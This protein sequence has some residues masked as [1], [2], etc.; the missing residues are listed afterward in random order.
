MHKFQ[1]FTNLI[2]ISCPFS[3][4]PSDAQ[5]KDGLK[6]YFRSSG[7]FVPGCAGIPTAALDYC[8]DPVLAKGSV[9]ATNNIQDQDGLGVD[10]ITTLI[11]PKPT[12]VMIQPTPT[13]SPTVAPEAKP[14]AKPTAKPMAKPTAKPTPNPT[15]APQPE[16]DR[17]R[18]TPC[19]P[20]RDS[21]WD[22]ICEARERLLECKKKVREEQREGRAAGA[23]DIALRPDGR[24]LRLYCRYSYLWQE[25]KQYCPRY[26]LEASDKKVGATLEIKDCSRSSPLQKFR[27][28]DGVIR[29]GWHG[30]ERLCI[31]SDKL[32]RCDKPL[33]YEREGN[34]AHFEIILEKEENKRHELCF[35]NPHHPKPWY[36]LTGISE[37]KCF[38]FLQTLVIKDT[39]DHPNLRRFLSLYTFSLL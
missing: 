20:T 9:P 13:I 8:M 12:E 5:C 11:E 14:T 6:C 37:A 30:G 26:C 17:D 28:E 34:S 22:E 31:R 3:C 33:V 2:Y 29:P 1:I 4:S 10:G 15:P 36:V 35:S 32:E 7:Q 27:M 18:P 21:K 39:C 23:E 19:P 24:N 16:P 38:F 25:K